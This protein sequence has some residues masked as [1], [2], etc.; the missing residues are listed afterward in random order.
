MSRVAK[1]E[2]FFHSKFYHL[3]ASSLHDDKCVD[4]RKTL[5]NVGSHGA[6]NLKGRIWLHVLLQKNMNQWRLLLMQ[7]V[8][9]LPMSLLPNQHMSSWIMIQERRLFTDK[10]DQWFH[11]NLRNICFKIN[12]LQ[13]FWWFYIYLFWLHKNHSIYISYRNIWVKYSD[14]L[15]SS[16]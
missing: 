13:K 6:S 4:I 9:I 11:L 12:S 7:I 8:L 15:K 10:Q 1:R 5:K 14:L 3:F 16:K 2:P